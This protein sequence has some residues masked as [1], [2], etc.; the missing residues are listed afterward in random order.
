MPELLSTDHRILEKGFMEWRPFGVSR[1]GQKIRDVSGMTVRANL[2]YLEDCLRRLEGP[3]AADH[4]AAELCRS[5]NACIREPAYHVTP[6]FLKNIWNSYSYEFVMFLAELCERRTGDAD[7][8]MHVG[9][10]FIVPI[11][12]TLGRPFSVAQIYRM[13]AHFG[14]KFAKGSIVY[15]VDCVT[16]RSAILRLK[17]SDQVYEQFG[18]YRNACVRLICQCV[19]AALAS[20]PHQVHHWQPATLIDRTCITNGDEYCE[21]EIKWTPQPASRFITVPVTLGVMLIA[22]MTSGAMIQ[23]PMLAHVLLSLFTGSTAL[24]AINWWLLHEDNQVRQDLI[25]EQLEFVD[26]RHEELR[27]AYLVQE[28]TTVE[29]RQKIHHL[30]TLH[31]TGLLFSSTL[32]RETLV[33]SILETLVHELHYDRAMLSFYDAARSVTH[34]VRILGVSEEIQRFARALEVPVADPDSLE[35]VVLLQGQPLLVSD[36]QEVKAR[37]HPLNRQLADLIGTP[38]LISVPLRVK[39]RMIGALT[40]DRRL[41]QL[42]KQD[43]LELMVTVASQ[44]SIAL[45]NAQ[46]YQTIE[47]LNITLES[48][49]QDRTAELRQIVG[50]LEAANEQLKHVDRLKSM[51]LSHLSHELRTPL[52]AIRGFVE[53]MLSGC[54]GALAERQAHYLVRVKLNA[55]RLIRMIADLLDRTRIESGKLELTR[56]E[57]LLPKLARDV[58]EQLQPLAEA[59]EQ[60]LEVRCDDEQLVVWAD[61]DKLSQI[62]TNLL[63][64]AIKFTQEGGRITLSLQQERGRLARISVQ[65]TG[66]G[67]E[68]VDVPRLFDPFFQVMREAH[69]SKGLGLGL[70]IVKTL[71]ELHGGDIAVQSERGAGTT[72]HVRIPLHKK[73]GG[74]TLS[75]LGK[76]LLIVDDDADIRKMLADRLESEGYVVETASEGRSALEALERAI[77][78]GVLLDIGL[79]GL[80]GIKVLQRIRSKDLS[81]AVIM[82]TASENRERAIEAIQ[83]GAQAF[84]L[85]PFQAARL[86]EVIERWFGTPR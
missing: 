33:K 31:R 18:P 9:G 73:D 81:L 42:L 65:D 35:G 11:I 80:D 63:D 6:V 37:M 32:D 69:R 86:K 23:A 3:A 36:L 59:K 22:W 30:T 77:F 55:D 60:H 70:S 61:W 54:V 58:A 72:F 78:H 21:W 56:V 85:K 82:I 24:C 48:R 52:T 27:E 50:E 75:A 64:N 62:L 45:D 19:K 10:R 74:P 7:F 4:A 1:T 68:A 14:D 46:A 71:V 40:V 8:Q 2:D 57:V 84:V 44:V 12:Q 25:Q 79:P 16:S 67:I 51:F 26:A 28:Q 38:A 20:V 5:L 49:V 53:N 17:F 29:L 47:A 83:L 15:G 66:Q 43:D 34:E 41:P 76:H 13:F 39:D